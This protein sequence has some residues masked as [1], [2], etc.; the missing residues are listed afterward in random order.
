MSNLLGIHWIVTTHGTWLH[1]DPR[2]SWRNGKLIGSD[3]FMEDAVR[4]RMSADA[5]VLV[6]NEIPIVAESFGTTSGEH[7]WRGAAATIQATH[8]HVVFRVMREPIKSVI[9]RLKYRSARAVWTARRERGRPTPRSLWTGG[10]FPVFID[11]AAHLENAVA[12]VRAHNLRSGLPAEPYA[13]I[14]V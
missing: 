1:G 10:Q 8:A 14:G 4:A 11:D 2:G 6:D 12:Y 9:A 3:P 7:G 5:V 13:W